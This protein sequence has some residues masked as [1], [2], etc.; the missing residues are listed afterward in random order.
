MNHLTHILTFLLTVQ[1]VVMIVLIFVSGLDEVGPSQTE[2]KY[3]KLNFIPF[4]WVAYIINVIFKGF[5][6]ILK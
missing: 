4:Y 5:K 3:I 1:Y 6:K 2:K